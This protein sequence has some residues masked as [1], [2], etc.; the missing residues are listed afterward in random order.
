M[1]V[2]PLAFRLCYK[3]DAFTWGALLFQPVL[4]SSKAQPEPAFPESVY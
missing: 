2:G 1:L 4:H 3:A